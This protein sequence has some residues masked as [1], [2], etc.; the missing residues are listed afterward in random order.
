[1]FSCVSEDR[2]KMSRDLLVGEAR[3]FLGSSGLGFL[4]H[5]VVETLLGSSGF[6]IE[7]LMLALMPLA[8]E[9]SLSEISGFRVGAIG[10]GASGALYLGANF[11]FPSCALNQ[12]IHAEQ[13]VVVNAYNHG[14]NGLLRLAVSA[15]PCG[16]CR[17]FLYELNSAQELRVIL[18][19][20]PTS[21]LADYLPHAFGP[22]DLGVACG[23]FSH[24]DH[25]LNYLHDE[26]VSQE[27]EEAFQGARRSYAPYS[28]SYAG[29]AF[30][31]TDGA[32][33]SSSY[34]ENAA[35][36]PSLLPMQAA[37]LT[38]RLSGHGVQEVRSV[39]V[40]QCEDSK[41]DHA[42]AARD[43]CRMIWPDDDL[44]V[45]RILVSRE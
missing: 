21:L 16:H 15:A 4:P 32:V 40:V 35:F 37:Y 39:S 14:E 12:T 19:N 43:L 23:L 41:I 18:E 8:S 26:G 33:F 30:T 27:V 10:L 42:A 22:E 5:E 11:E 6:E 38:A 34:L 36:N 45:R 9:F 24:Q 29:L 2:R 25:A 17:Q 28:Q 7:E 20:T 3:R 44:P 1:M 13:A 31:T